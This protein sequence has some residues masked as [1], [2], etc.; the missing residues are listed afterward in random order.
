MTAGGM[1]FKLQKSNRPDDGVDALFAPVP[2]P[3]DVSGEFGLMTIPG[4]FYTRF[5]EFHPE[6]QRLAVAGTL[7]ALAAFARFRRDR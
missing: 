3:Y 1:G 2:G 5:F 7:L 4:N 6:R